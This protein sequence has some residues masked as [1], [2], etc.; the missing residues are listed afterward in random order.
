MINLENDSDVPRSE[1]FLF[2][3]PACIKHQIVACLIDLFFLTF[4]D[5]WESF[6]FTLDWLFPQ[7]DLYLFWLFK[8]FFRHP[9]WNFK[10]AAKN[11]WRKKNDKKKWIEIASNRSYLFGENIESWSHLSSSAFPTSQFEGLG[12]R[13]VNITM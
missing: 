2:F 8:A 6:H 13:L 3:Q 12:I 11:D 1:F 7:F 5:F 10:K 9:D 4:W